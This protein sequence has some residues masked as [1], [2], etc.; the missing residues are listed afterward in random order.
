MKLSL[1]LFS[2]APFFWA[3]AGFWIPK[4]WEKKGALAASIVL[5]I[6][7]FWLPS[8]AHSFLPFT[9]Q[10]DSLAKIFIWL[11]SFLQI[12]TILVSPTSLS[13]A[14]QYALLFLLQ[15]FAFGLFMTE[16]LLA[17]FFFWEA[18]LVPVYLGMA[19]FGG[20]EKKEALYSFILYMAFGSVALLVAISAV[21]A[22]FGSFSLS[23]WQEPLSIPLWVGGAF[24]LAFVV[25]TPLFPFHSWLPQ[26]YS[27]APLPF[28]LLLVALLSKVGIFGF[29]RWFPLIQESIHALQGPLVFL[30]LLG[31]VYAGFVAWGAP[32]LDS[33]LAYASLSHLNLLLTGLFVGGDITSFGVLFQTVQHGLTLFTLFLLIDWLEKKRCSLEWVDLGGIV[34]QAPRMTWWTFTF[35]LSLMSVPG[36]GS[37]VGEWLILLGIFRYSLIASVVVLSVWLL[38][39]IYAM[40]W[41]ERVYFGPSLTKV[42]VMEDLSWRQMACISPFFL[43][44]LGFGI[45]PEIFFQQLPAFLFGGP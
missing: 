7:S 20:E 30:S 45:Y 19:I 8:S 43:L 34:A 39:A 2:F 23:S 36:F 28:R 5:F 40:Q 27:A 3:L 33:L 15:G 31:A 14:L 18:L 41:M 6:A 9:L 42:V 10:V 25:K 12:A 32:R 26:T 38:S 35:L 4:G 44:M 13:P 17:F 37:F 22:E 29:F 16:H 24:I 1:E 21:Y 11:A